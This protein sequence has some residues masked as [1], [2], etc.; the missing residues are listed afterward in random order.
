MSSVAN[1]LKYLTVFLLIV[2][3]FFSFSACGNKGKV[4][5]GA[6]IKYLTEEEYLSNQIDEKMHSGLT[7]GVG[8]KGYVVVDFTLS[9]LTKI[10]ED[11]AASVE[12]RFSTNSLGKTELGVEELPTSDYSVEAAT[13]KANFKIYDSEKNEKSFRFI[14]S[15]LRDTPAEVSVQAVL[16][17]SDEK[18]KLSGETAWWGKVT[19]KDETT[20][21]SKLEFQLSSDETYYVVTGLG[22]ENGDKIVIPDKYKELPVK[23]IAERVF[24]DA[25]YLKEVTLPAEL[26]KIGAYA[27]QN[28]VS[29]ES[30]LI[31]LSVTEIGDGAFEGCTDI[32]LC[33]EIGEKPSA[34]S[35]NGIS[36][37]KSITWSCSRYFEFALET[38]GTSYVL[39]SANGVKGDTVIPGTY[40]GLP[41]AAV[42]SDAFKDNNGLTGVTIPDSV[43]QIGIRAFSG[44]G[45][46]TEIKIPD[47]VTYIGNN[48]FENCDSLIKV[49]LGSGIKELLNCTFAG[50]GSLTDVVIPSGILTV[51][52]DVFENC[53]DLERIKF[54]GTETQW[55]AVVKNDGWDGGS[56]SYTVIFN[57]AGE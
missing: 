52:H 7:V 12:I 46:L 17:V 37:V 9:G 34:W 51:W 48:A 54:R 26:A 49:T 2:I 4:T 25:S 5:S 16:S 23:E 20:E 15:V 22:G 24:S 14:I 53:G 28:C 29:L 30:V 42:G 44:C 11:T 41:V 45:G 55:N 33:C 21:E 56:V 13:A 39:K 10:N 35:E 3:T 40:K 19:V 18:V 1:R 47:S 27:F 6:S 32:H 57:Y 38:D 31:P 8:E 36:G 43:K 50:C